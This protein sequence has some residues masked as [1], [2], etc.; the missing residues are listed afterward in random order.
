MSRERSVSELYVRLSDTLVHDYDVAD[1]L[2]TLVEGCKDV[3]DVDVAGVLLEKRKDE[4]A[5]SAASSEDIRTLEAMELQTQSGPCYDAYR[6]HEQVI[7]EDLA[8]CEDRWPEFVP[9]ALGLGFRSG[10]GFPLR[11]RHEAI[12]ALNLYRETPGPLGE[13]DVYLAQSLADVATIGIVNERAIRDARVL[14]DQLQTALDSRVIIEQAKGALAER[15]G[16]SPNDAFQRMRRHCRD[17][18]TRLRDVSQRVVHEGFVP[19]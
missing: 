7:I 12:G 19:D 6:K 16:I 1:F 3:L 13:D 17:N 4:L 11:L 15:E 18:S 10:H 2:Q 14:T 5:L 9:K 8:A